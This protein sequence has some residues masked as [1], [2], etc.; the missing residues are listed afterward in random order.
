MSRFRL[1]RFATRTGRN[2]GVLFIFLCNRL[3]FPDGSR[4]DAGGPYR[5]DIA[6]LARNAQRVDRN[7]GTKEQNPVAPQFHV[8]KISGKVLTI[9]SPVEQAEIFGPMALL[10]VQSIQ[11]R[12]LP[13]RR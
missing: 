8:R 6:I 4:G 2:L 7:Q 5:F 12:S 1:L 3:R 13:A 11:F 9:A 10:Y